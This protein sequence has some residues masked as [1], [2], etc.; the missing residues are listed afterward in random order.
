MAPPGVN[1]R[2]RGTVDR[3]AVPHDVLH[4]GDERL[5]QL[6]STF[7]RDGPQ[8]SIVRDPL[9]DARAL[10]L[11]GLH[12]Q[13]EPHAQA[14]IDLLADL[15]LKYRPLLTATSMSKTVG[16]APWDDIF[17]HRWIR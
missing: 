12:L 8:L 16:M 3:A 7:G 6:V 4:H 2:I 5:H 15:Y 17:R 9:E 13:D 11:E 14:R 1:A 10:V